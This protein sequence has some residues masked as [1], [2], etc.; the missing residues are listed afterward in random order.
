MKNPDRIKNLLYTLSFIALIFIILVGMKTAA[1]FVNIMLVSL[2]LTLLGIPLMRWLKKA[3]LSDALA[4]TLIIGLYIICIFGFLF[5]IY[6]SAYVFVS[7]LPAYE[8]L[9]EERLSQ[10]MDIIGGFGITGDMIGSVLK[11]DWNAISKIALGVIAGGSMIAMNLFFILVITCFALLEV[12]KVSS[13]LVRVYGENSGKVESVRNVISNIIKW[14]VVKTKTNVVLGASFGGLLY[15]LGVDMA[16]FWGLMA[17]IL[18][19]IPYV[20][21]IIVAIPAIFLAWLQIGIWGAVVVIA[22]IC[23]INAV[24]ENF[25]FSKFAADSFQIPPLIVIV[26]LILWSWVLGP[27]GLFLSVPFTVIIIALLHGSE[28]TKW[29]TILLGFDDPEA[30]KE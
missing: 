28:D 11:P 4:V 30:V 25:V 2:I 10:L 3:G 21:L 24:V 13:R 7:R 20:G 29:I 6:E 17:V 14:L 5:L 18:S 16:I 27:I 23:V 12:P 9:L 26:T 19:Y 1:Y 8:S 22:G 15:V